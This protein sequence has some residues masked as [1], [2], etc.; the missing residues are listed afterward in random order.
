MPRPADSH[1]V[2]VGCPDCAGVLSVRTDN[3]HRE[4]ECQIG[5][6]YSILSAIAAKEAQLERTLWEAH[7]LLEH[8]EVLMTD[9]LNDSIGQEDPQL[10]AEATRRRVEAQQQYNEL[11]D[12][13]ERG[14]PIAIDQPCRP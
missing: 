14:K 8:V 12:F 5:H 10:L 2:L 6:R 9:L 7:S 11:R 1:P 4:Y 13:I 3:G